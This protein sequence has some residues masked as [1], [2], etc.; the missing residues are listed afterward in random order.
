MRKKSNSSDKAGGGLIYKVTFTCYVSL[1]DAE[2]AVHWNG[3]GSEDC[4]GRRTSDQN[5]LAGASTRLTSPLLFYDRYSS[6]LLYHHFEEKHFW[7]LSAYKRTRKKKC[8]L[9]NREIH[10]YLSVYWNTN[11]STKDDAWKM[12]T[13]M[14]I[15]GKY[16]TFRD[17]YTKRHTCILIYK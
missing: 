1:I 5:K 9:A 14:N 15:Y 13:F 6:V 8:V 12:C 7:T 2:T 4:H 16:S 3:K 17:I 10:V 11:I